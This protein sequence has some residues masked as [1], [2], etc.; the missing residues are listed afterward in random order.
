MVEI[1]IA[2]RGVHPETSLFKIGIK[3]DDSLVVILLH[4]AQTVGWAPL[5][6]GL[7]THAR[8]HWNDNRSNSHRLQVHYGV[9][10]KTA[11]VT[12]TNHACGKSFRARSKSRLL[13]F[14]RFIRVHA[15][16]FSLREVVE[17]ESHCMAVPHSP[18]R[19]EVE[20]RSSRIPKWSNW[21][22][23]DTEIPVT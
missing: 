14:P 11:L 17:G 22:R 18:T 3:D 23:F 9:L 5:H 13:P 10:F 12:C 6:G 16:D 7:R 20:C 1:G 8:G 19:W 2:M 21:A 4:P 15:G